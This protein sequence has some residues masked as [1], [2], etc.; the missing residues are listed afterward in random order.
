[1]REKLFASPQTYHSYMEEGEKNK[2]KKSLQ[3]YDQLPIL[4]STQLFYTNVR[5]DIFQGIE[6]SS[7][8]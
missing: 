8:G 5:Q 4:I 7:V 1:V 3:M 6:P 2:Q